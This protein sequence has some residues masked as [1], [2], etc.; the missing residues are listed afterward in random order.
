MTQLLFLSD[1]VTAFGGADGEPVTTESLLGR[2]GRLRAKA[3][4]ILKELNREGDVVVC[5]PPCGTSCQTLRV[6]APIGRQVSH[7][8][9]AD[10]LEA[11]LKKAGGDSLAVICAEPSRVLLDGEEVTGSPVGK[12]AQTLEVEITAF[13]SPL[14]FLAA[15][16]GAAQDAGLTLKGV[17]AMEEAASA[18]L[19]SGEGG[20]PPLVFVDL[21]HT[22]IVG[23]AGDAMAASTTIP[24]GSGHIA[25]DLAVTFSISDQEAEDL[26]RQILLGRTSKKTE[27]K[28]HVVEA[29]LDELAQ[30]TAE[31]VG[32][33]GIAVEDPILVGIAP[34]PKVVEAF[35][36]YGLS[37]RSPRL[38]LKKTDPPPLTLVPG[39][40]QIAAG[41]VP[42]S[43]A[44]ALQLAAPKERSGP[45]RWLLR[46]F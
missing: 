27:D 1:H 7:T 33:A 29:R 16:E 45:L 40:I 6:R 32:K 14:S 44:T 23:F 30:K 3:S 41:A 11:A 18:S 5:L 46:N 24:I 4:E 15:L 38:E 37:V 22:K 43:A 34:T 8:D 26:A 19:S 17:M 31:A 13:L 42:R 28:A 9:L 39:A 36:R 25:S 10:A 35:G 2:K 21:W 20:K 12:P